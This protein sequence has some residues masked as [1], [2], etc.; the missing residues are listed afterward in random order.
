MSH[1]V[2]IMLSLPGWIR[3]H[4]DWFVIECTL[5]ALRTRSFGAARGRSAL[6]RRAAHG[7][8][9]ARSRRVPRERKAMH[10]TNLHLPNTARSLIAAGDLL[11]ASPGI[12]GAQQAPG[13]NVPTPPP[14]AP[15]GAAPITPGTSTTAAI[16]EP[17][18]DTTTHRS[19]LP[20]KP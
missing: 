18:I 19:S 7:A 2:F 4:A 20:N 1:V 12:A 6:V 10:T 11:I 8:Q 14:P 9:L 17:V 15:A 3:L 13:T 5:H 16:E